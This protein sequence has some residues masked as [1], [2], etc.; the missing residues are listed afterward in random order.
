MSQEEN[1][2]WPSFG[3]VLN[4]VAPGR[5]ESLTRERGQWSAQTRGRLIETPETVDLNAAWPALAGSDGVQLTSELVPEPLDLPEP[6]APLEL[7]TSKVRELLEARSTSEHLDVSALAELAEPIKAELFDDSD[8][9]SAIDDPDLE[10]TDTETETIEAELEDTE[11]EEPEADPDDLLL[12][13]QDQA[14]EIFEDTESDDPFAIEAVKFDTE[15]PFATDE[16]FTVE[17]IEPTDENLSDDGIAFGDT[18]TTEDPFATTTEDP[19]ATTTEDPFAF[20]P[21]DT[22]TENP[23]AFEPTDTTTEDPFA[24]TTENPFTFEPTDTTTEDPFAVD[25]G[26][27]FGDDITDELNSN[28]NVISL[29]D[30]KEDWDE[31]TF[32][33]IEVANQIEGDLLGLTDVEDNVVPILGS[34]EPDANHVEEYEFLGFNSSL[35]QSATDWSNAGFELDGDLDG[36]HEWR[37]L[38]DPGSEPVLED[39]AEPTPDPWEHMRPTEEENLGWWARRP[40][41]LGG[42]GTSEADSTGP[43]SL[44]LSYDSDCPECGKEGDVQEEDLLSRAVFLECP[45][46]ENLWETQYHLDSEAS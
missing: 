17:P 1:F 2:E 41:W 10:E 16:A 20:E 21:T 34:S 15:D 45:K 43:K 37:K 8:T 25:E 9:D 39:N 35:D 31:N 23:F 4:E 32:N 12:E 14:E 6:L 22:T 7:D 33:S 26:I 3:A 11:T 40:R 19:F 42:S 36:Q 46:C 18:T 28:E 29:F 27:T 24:T 13:S 38:D 5:E 44:G 30:K